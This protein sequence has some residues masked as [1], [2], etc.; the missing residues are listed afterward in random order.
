[1]DREGAGVPLS[2]D[3]TCRRGLAA[4]LAGEDLAT[5]VEVLRGA[6]SNPAWAAACQGPIGDGA[7][8]L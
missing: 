1:M 4:G 2:V 6:R 8:D 7:P 5:L 3:R